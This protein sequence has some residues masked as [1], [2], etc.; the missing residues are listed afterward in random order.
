MKKALLVVDM[1]EIYVGEEH[2]AFFKYDMETLVKQVN[3]VI[4]SYEGQLVIYIRNIMKKNFINKLAPVKV[5]DGW[6]EAQLAGKLHVVS[7]YMIEKYVGNAFS[8]PEL[9]TLLKEH[10]IDEVE[11]IGVDGGGCVALTAFGACKAGYQVTMNTK[12][13]GTMLIGKQKKYNKRLL[14]LGVRFI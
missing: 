5:Y 11:L 8:N 4:D 1:Q 13:I 14:K 3:Q 6:K 9:N 12:A 2:N 10:N 7:D